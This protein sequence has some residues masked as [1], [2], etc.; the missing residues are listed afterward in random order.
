MKTLRIKWDSAGRPTLPEMSDAIRVATPLVM[1]DYVAHLEAVVVS[2]SEYVD[3]PGEATG[4]R[5]QQVV[6]NSGG[7]S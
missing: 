4:G 6:G 7:A 2:M 5:Q 3:M 1:L